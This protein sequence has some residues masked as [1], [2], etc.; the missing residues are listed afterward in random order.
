VQ[1]NTGITRSKWPLIR[2]NKS[3][4]H[5]LRDHRMRTLFSV[6]GPF[7]AKSTNYNIGAI[8]TQ[9]VSYKILRSFYSCI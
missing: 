2:V 9:N 5:S 3:L 8:G 7:N 4:S 1:Q 6:V